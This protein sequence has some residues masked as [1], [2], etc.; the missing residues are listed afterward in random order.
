MARF[1]EIP[2][3]QKFIYL[4][5]ILLLGDKTEDEVVINDNE[6]IYS[7][8]LG[9]GI[10]NEFIPKSLKINAPCEYENNEIKNRT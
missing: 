2:T 7:Y 9:E 5:N 6:N 10:N 1:S 4:P 3:N 8:I